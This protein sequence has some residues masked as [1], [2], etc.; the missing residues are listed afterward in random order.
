MR[1]KSLA[2]ARWFRLASSDEC[3]EQNDCLQAGSDLLPAPDK[4]PPPGHQ[5]RSFH[6]EPKDLCLMTSDAVVLLHGFL[7]LVTYLRQPPPTPPAGRHLVDSHPQIFAFNLLPLVSQGQK[8]PC[9]H[10]GWGGRIFHTC[11][12]IWAPC[13]GEEETEERRGEELFV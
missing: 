9:L 3:G 10:T 11:G 7:S 5:S 6:R 8:F 13:C 1:L 12:H 4:F 2:F